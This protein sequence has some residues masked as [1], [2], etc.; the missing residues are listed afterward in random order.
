[1]EPPWYRVS[2][3]YE[4]VGEDRVKCL[5]CSR[6]CVLGEGAKGFCG[7]RVNKDGRLYCVSYGLLSAVE[8]RP[9]EIKPL[10][11]YWPNSTSLTF[12]GWG[13]NFKCPWC[14]NYFLSMADPRPEHSIY[15]S[16]KSLV[17]EAIKR[18]DEGVCASFNEPVVHAEYVIDVAKI[19][20]EYGLYTVIVTNGYMTKRVLEEML[21]AGIDGYSMDIKCCPETCRRILGIDPY[22]VLSNAKY[23]ID[24]GGHVEMVYLIVTGANDSDECI[25]WIIDNHLKYLGENVPLHINRYYPAY[26]YNKPPTPLDTLF[27]AYNKAREAGIKYVYL[28]NIS[29][30]K[31]QDTYCPKCGKLLVK[32][33]RYRVVEWKLTRDNRCPRCGEKIPVKGEYVPGKSLPPLF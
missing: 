14:Q 26:K 12:S 3:F 13:C 17:L 10:F 11:H 5:V 21:E 9:I 32:R 2:R 19:A 22:V 4:K 7:N 25:D 15:L 1:M 29:D 6:G 20:R 28:G 16:P 30:E 24:N 18:G 33:R 23:I 27:K 31:Y 8:S